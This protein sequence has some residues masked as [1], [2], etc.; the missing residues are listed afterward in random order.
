VV[1]LC[2]E[3]DGST[4]AGEM[5]SNNDLACTTP[6]ISCRAIPQDISATDIPEELQFIKVTSRARCSDGSKF[7]VE[8]V[9]EV[10]V[11]GE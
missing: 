5:V 2:G 4:S 6:T 8:R 11:K 1:E 3:I 9:Q 7:E 10:W